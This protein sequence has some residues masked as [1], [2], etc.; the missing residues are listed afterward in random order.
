MQLAVVPSLHTRL[1]TMFHIRK[2]M[3][4]K[5]GKHIWLT[6][7]A[8]MQYIAQNITIPVPNA[9]TLKDGGHLS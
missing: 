3:V 6:E 1:T 8:T 9:W 7:A 4:L 5:A 2:N